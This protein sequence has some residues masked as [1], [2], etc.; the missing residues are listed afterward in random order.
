V[1]K[2]EIDWIKKELSLV[3]DKRESFGIDSDFPFLILIENCN[4]QQANQKSIILELP[5]FSYTPVGLQKRDFFF[6]TKF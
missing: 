4:F 5:R 2:S 1:Q 3:D 6:R